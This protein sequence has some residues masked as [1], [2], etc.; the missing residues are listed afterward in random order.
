MVLTVLKVYFK[1]R[2]PSVIQYCDYKKFSNDKFRIDLLNDLIRSK[3]E[4]SRLDLFVNAVLKVLNKN[5]PVKNCYFRANEASFKNKVLKKAMM[6]I[7]KN[8]NV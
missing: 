1:K 3:I 8:P 7:S 4:T 6:K 5:A 2:W